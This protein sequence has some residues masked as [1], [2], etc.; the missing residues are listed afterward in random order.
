[1]KR[2]LSFLGFTFLAF[3]L[4]ELIVKH[5]LGWWTYGS[6]WSMGETVYFVA[7]HVYIG[8]LLW[9]GMELML[10]KAAGYDIVRKRRNEVD[11]E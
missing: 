4:V 2:L 3:V 11:K 8:W 5:F 9:I 1:M 10:L 6:I 7:P